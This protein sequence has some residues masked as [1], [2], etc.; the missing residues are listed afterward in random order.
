MSNAHRRIFF[1]SLV[2][3]SLLSVLPE[4]CDLFEKSPKLS[5][6]SFFNIYFSSYDCCFVCAST[7][8]TRI[9]FLPIRVD[10]RMVGTVL[11]LA[12]SERDQKKNCLWTRYLIEIWLNCFPTF[13][14]SSIRMRKKTNIAQDNFPAIN[15]ICS[16]ESPECIFAFIFDM[17]EYLWRFRMVPTERT[18][19]MNRDSEIPCDIRLQPMFTLSHT[20]QAK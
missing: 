13:F 2:D 16:Q 7:S 14:A 9:A 3:W 8:S 15:F 5:S 6:S 4:I 20:R 18:T 17:L 11:Y 19:Q 10:W 1:H 12:V